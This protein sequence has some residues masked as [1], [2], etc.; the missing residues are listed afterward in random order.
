MGMID[1]MSIAVRSDNGKLLKKCAAA[2]DQIE[3]AEETVADLL[4]S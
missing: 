3:I 1:R 4:K 2:L